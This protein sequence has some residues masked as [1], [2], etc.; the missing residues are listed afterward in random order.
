MDE[1]LFASSQ[2]WLEEMEAAGCPIAVPADVDTSTPLGRKR[3]VAAVDY[4]QSHGDANEGWRHARAVHPDAGGHASFAADGG[5]GAAGGYPSFAADAAGIVFNPFDDVPVSR[6]YEDQPVAPPAPPAPTNKWGNPV[7]PPSTGKWGNPASQ[8]VTGKWGNPARHPGNK[9]GTQATQ[10]PAPPSSKWAHPAA[11]SQPVT[12]DTL[13]DLRKQAVTGGNPALDAAEQRRNQYTQRWGVSRKPAAGAGTASRRNVVSVDDSDSDDGVVETLVAPAPQPV[14]DVEALIREMEAGRRTAPDT[15]DLTGEYEPVPTHYGV[16]V[17]PAVPRGLETFV[18]M[19]DAGV[20]LGDTF[21]LVAAARLLTGKPMRAADIGALVD[22]TPDERRAFLATMVVGGGDGVQFPT[23]DAEVVGTALATTGVIRNAFT[24][25][26]WEPVAAAINRYFTAAR[27]GAAP[28]GDDLLQTVT[29]ALAAAAADAAAMLGRLLCKRTTASSRMVSETLN[30]DYVNVATEWD[31]ST[32]VAD[33]PER[34][35]SAVTTTAFDN[36]ALDNSTPMTRPSARVRGE[37]TATGAG[38]LVPTQADVG[39]SLSRVDAYTRADANAASAKLPDAVAAVARDVVAVVRANVRA[40]ADAVRAVIIAD[41]FTSVIVWPLNP[42]MPR[43]ILKFDVDAPMMQLVEALQLCAQSAQRVLQATWASNTVTRLHAAVQVARAH[44]DA[45]DEARPPLPDLFV[46]VQTASR[47]AVMEWRSTVAAHALQK[48]VVAAMKLRLSGRLL[49]GST[50]PLSRDAFVALNGVPTARELSAAAARVTEVYLIRLRR[51]VPGLPSSDGLREAVRR[52]VEVER[53]LDSLHGVPAVGVH[54]FALWLLAQLGCGR[55]PRGDDAGEAGAATGMSRSAVM[56]AAW[57]L[58]QNLRQLCSTPH[59]DHVAKPARE[60]ALGAMPKLTAP[61][62]ALVSRIVDDAY[63]RFASVYAVHDAAIGNVAG[64]MAVAAAC[65]V[66]IAAGADWFNRAVDADTPKEDVDAGV[67]AVF[68]EVRARVREGMLA[69][70]NMACGVSALEDAAQLM[71]MQPDAATPWTVDAMK[72]SGVGETPAWLVSTAAGLMG[73]AAAAPCP[74]DTL[75]ATCAYSA[76]YVRAVGDGMVSYVTAAVHNDATVETRNGDHPLNMSSTWQRQAGLVLRAAIEPAPVAFPESQRVAHN[77]RVAVGSSGRTFLGRPPVLPAT[78]RSVAQ[79]AFFACVAAKGGL[80]PGHSVTAIREIRGLRNAAT[81]MDNTCFDTLGD[82]FGLQPDL[83]ALRAAAESLREEATRGAAEAGSATDTDAGRLARGAGA[84]AAGDDTSDSDTLVE[85]DEDDEVVPAAVRSVELREESAQNL[86]AAQEVLDFVQL[87]MRCFQATTAR[88]PAYPPVFRT[89]APVNKRQGDVYL[90]LDAEDAAGNLFLDRCFKFKRADLAAWLRSMTD[91]GADAAATAQAPWTSHAGMGYTLAITMQMFAAAFRIAEE[92]DAC[93]PAGVELSRP[94]YVVGRLLIHRLLTQSWAD[95]G[96]A[97]VPELIA[98][99]D[100]APDVFRQAAVHA[101]NVDAGLRFATHRVAMNRFVAGALTSAE[102]CDAFMNTSHPA[103]AVYRAVQRNDAPADDPVRRHGPVVTSGVMPAAALEH[104]V[105]QAL[106]S[107]PAGYRGVAAVPGG[108]RF[109]EQGFRVPVAPTV[110]FARALHAHATLARI[111]SDGALAEADVPATV[112]V[113]PLPADA[114]DGRGDESLPAAK[115][116]LLRDSLPPMDAPLPRSASVYPF[117]SPAM[118]G[119]VAAVPGAAPKGPDATGVHLAGVLAQYLA[120]TT[121]G[122]LALLA[123]RAVAGANMGSPADLYGTGTPVK[124]DPERI[125]ERAERGGVLTAQVRDAMYAH[126]DAKRSPDNLLQYADVVASMQMWAAC[127]AFGAHGVDAVPASFMTADGR[128]PVRG[129]WMTVNGVFPVPALHAFVR[130]YDETVAKFTPWNPHEEKYVRGYAYGKWTGVTPAAVQDDIPAGVP[131]GTQDHAKLATEAKPMF[132]R[133]KRCRVLQDALQRSMSAPVLKVALCGAGGVALDAAHI[134]E[135]TLFLMD[136]VTSVAKRTLFGDW[137]WQGADDAYAVP[138][139]FGRFVKNVL[140]VV[141]EPRRKLIKQVAALRAALDNDAPGSPA[142]EED[143]SVLVALE[144]MVER[145]EPLAS[146][147]AATDLTRAE[148][149]TLVDAVDAAKAAMP[150]EPTQFTFHDRFSVLCSMAKFVPLCS[151]TFTVGNVAALFTEWAGDDPARALRVAPLQ[152]FFT[153]LAQNVYEHDVLLLGR[154]HV[155]VLDANIRVGNVLEMAK[156]LDTFFVGETHGVHHGEVMPPEVLPTLAKTVNVAVG[157]L[158]A[159]AH[160]PHVVPPGVDTAPAGDVR[161]A[162]PAGSPGCAGVHHLGLIAAMRD[163]ALAAR[164]MATSDMAAWWSRHVE[165]LVETGRPVWPLHSPALRFVTVDSDAMPSVARRAQAGPAVA[166]DG[167]S[168]ARAQTRLVA[169]RPSPDATLHQS[170]VRLFDLYAAARPDVFAAENPGVDV[171]DVA[172]WL[173]DGHLVQVPHGTGIIQGSSPGRT[174]ACMARRVADVLAGVHQGL[175]TVQGQTMLARLEAF[176]A[177]CGYWGNVV[178]ATQPDGMGDSPYGVDATVAAAATELAGFRYKMPSWGR[179]NA[180]WNSM[181]SHRAHH[182]EV[183]DVPDWMHSM[184][185]RKLMPGTLE[186]HHEQHVVTA[187]TNT[188]H[189]GVNMVRTDMSWVAEAAGVDADGFQVAGPPSRW[190]N[191]VVPAGDN[192]DLVYAT[193][194]ELSEADIRREEA[195][196]ASRGLRAHNAMAALVINEVTRRNA[197]HMNPANNA[198]RWRMLAVGEPRT[199]RSGN[200]SMATMAACT[201]NPLEVVALLDPVSQF[202]HSRSLVPGGVYAPRNHRTV[203]EPNAIQEALVATGTC[204]SAWDGLALGP[205]VP[206]VSAAAATC[207][208]MAGNINPDPLYPPGGASAV[209]PRMDDGKGAWAIV[210]DAKR[211]SGDTNNACCACAFETALQTTDMTQWALANGRDLVSAEAVT[212]GLRKLSHRASTL[213]PAAAASGSTL[214]DYLK[215][216][217]A[218]THR[219]YGRLALVGKPA[220]ETTSRG[221]WFEGH[222]EARGDQAALMQMAGFVPAMYPAFLRAADVAG[223]D[224]LLQHAMYRVRDQDSANVP[225]VLGFTY[226]VL[227]TLVP[228]PGAAVPLS[229]AAASHRGLTAR[230]GLGRCISQLYAAVP[231]ALGPVLAAQADPWEALFQLTAAVLA[232]QRVADVPAVWRRDEDGQM[233][234]FSVRRVCLTG[235]LMAAWPPGK[236]ATAA[237]IVYWM[238]HNPHAGASDEMW[239][240][241]ADWRVAD[242]DVDDQE[243]GF[244]R[245][246]FLHGLWVLMTCARVQALRLATTQYN[247]GFTTKHTD[248]QMV[249]PGVQPELVPEDEELRLEAAHG[250]TFGTGANPHRVTVPVGPPTSATEKLLHLVR[251]NGTTGEFKASNAWLM[252]R[253][254]VATVFAFLAACRAV[255]ATPSPAMVTS[256]YVAG[257]R[258]S[259]RPRQ[260][261]GTVMEGL[262]AHTADAV[263]GAIGALTVDLSVFRGIAYSA[264]DFNPSGLEGTLVDVPGV[265]VWARSLSTATN[266]DGVCTPE[267]FHCAGDAPWQL[268]DFPFPDSTL[269]GMNAVSGAQLT[270]AAGGDAL[271]TS[272]VFTATKLSSRD[273]QGSAAG[274]MGESMWIAPDA[275]GGYVNVDSHSRSGLMTGASNSSQA[276]RDAHG[277]MGWHG[278]DVGTL[279]ESADVGVRGALRDAWGGSDPRLTRCHGVLSADAVPPRSQVARTVAA[280]G[281]C[282]GVFALCWDYLPNQAVV[283]SAEVATANNLM[284]Q[285]MAYVREG[286]AADHAAATPDPDPDAML[287]ARRVRARKESVVAAEFAAKVENAGV[288]G[289]TAEAV[290]TGASKPSPASFY[291]GTVQKLARR[292]SILWAIVRAQ[293]SRNKHSVDSVSTNVAPGASGAI[294]LGTSK[295]QRPVDSRAWNSRQ[296]IGVT[297]TATLRSATNVDL[298]M[299]TP[300]PATHARTSGDALIVGRSVAE[301]PGN[302]DHPVA[303][304]PSTDDSVSFSGGYLAPSFGRAAYNTPSDAVAYTAIAPAVHPNTA[305]TVDAVISRQ[306]GATGGWCTVM[307]RSA[308]AVTSVRLTGLTPGAFPDR[309]AVD[310]QA[311]IMAGIAMGTPQGQRPSWRA[312]SR[313]VSPIT[314]LVMADTGPHAVVGATNLVAAQACAALGLDPPPP[315]DVP[316]PPPFVAAAP[317]DGNVQAPLDSISG[318]GMQYARRSQRGAGVNYPTIND[319]V[320]NAAHGGRPIVPRPRE[321]PAVKRDRDPRHRGSAVRP[322]TRRSRKGKAMTLKQM[323][324]AFPHAMGAGADL[325]SSDTEGDEDGGLVYDEEYAYSSP[326]SSR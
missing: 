128:P 77:N 243:G 161:I 96:L 61:A 155:A 15:V 43:H 192:A 10:P 237:G 80:D 218:G 93:G 58:V 247:A 213:Q 55:Q 299:M 99:S 284:P 324:A 197:L 257:S 232:S 67:D 297:V 305:A 118:R 147:A 59:L 87:L 8:P 323:K 188:R 259:L 142:A 310:L 229:G 186:H 283:L 159:V 54:A 9:W 313:L 113:S 319:V 317:F 39:A 223:A 236:R 40:S 210:R 82:H 136:L 109:D 248:G 1:G 326:S 83:K 270:A 100:A 219:M 268:Q 239:P 172:K 117:G 174:A 269:A 123:R 169:A 252:T 175:T 200:L 102:V 22:T 116:M 199:L 144:I 151:A 132:V 124:A 221:L 97:D 214:V 29:V 53:L 84:A 303:A 181:E 152:A 198:Y 138:R 7:G 190:A 224:R 242:D 162:W 32:S 57:L 157:V 256:N 20:G 19:L 262:R 125:R 143:A 231:V 272:I 225:D 60:E 95:G 12:G 70:F 134:V 50:E 170:N 37:R 279:A 146:V 275:G 273:G 78:S 201:T 280:G 290:T 133:A 101:V 108:A 226:A 241:H 167:F 184:R 233:A 312:A 27:A 285:R 286:D 127:V 41:A 206:G 105:R 164:V 238:A 325:P 6:F 304:D 48:W 316:A 56:A 62:A 17:E 311:D 104:V 187:H 156:P 35:T 33:N 44:G 121:N 287:E 47:D 204:M 245:D 322:P 131:P 227:A 194:L 74:V 253:P 217:R 274:S 23:R 191:H 129:M 292:R 154:H 86:A 298:R 306:L 235:A 149:A 165:A 263:D 16:P 202:D 282:P 255:A 26:H 205:R 158:L 103:G 11:F 321:H 180:G 90:D 249:W 266:I 31:S 139:T 294:G 195:A 106:W 208:Y 278:I 220:A 98:D 14:D 5:D 73:A 153:T 296:G 94:N 69:L 211:E 25:T 281:L 209:I 64:S 126:A 267:A 276:G 114:T 234:W 163:V 203:G 30:E 115:D 212:G 166:P 320:T 145:L 302:R 2:S 28:D 230:F 150:M 171:D 135:H 21:T 309:S 179:N 293:R 260:V 112:L 85:G 89:V 42:G 130:D 120:D 264:P 168:M 189:P 13:D 46:K 258:A 289:L 107:S 140:A 271:G 24:T 178:H 18:A 148:V 288:I 111:S 251:C 318:P 228:V 45:G 66:V 300:V 176:M 240:R 246:E 185:P 308:V 307:R 250:G 265:H 49:S 75:V 277:F 52:G 314:A 182:A 81:I 196:G 3:L 36:V 63:R 71:V 76:D 68:H 38:V 216:L 137:L 193:A 79:A 173:R 72:T 34:R 91:P 92:Q 315:V 261:V 51:R 291:D 215:I 160:T 4:M 65:P 244:T 254:V 110:G 119:V 301:G 222:S 183:T 88:I 177:T 122:R 141:K 207:I 295:V